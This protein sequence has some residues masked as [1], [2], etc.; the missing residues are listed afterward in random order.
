[1]RDILDM[2]GGD[3]GILPRHVQFHPTMKLDMW[4]AHGMSKVQCQAAHP[5]TSGVG[6]APRETYPLSLADAGNRRGLMQMAFPSV[7]HNDEFDYFC[8]EPFVT[9]INQHKMLRHILQYRDEHGHFPAAE[10]PTLKAVTPLTL[11]LIITLTL[12]LALTLTITLTLTP[13]LT[14]TLTLILTL[15]L[16][17][18]LTLIRRLC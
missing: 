16:T 5:A 18:I 17:L 3:T 9:R 4:K 11:T 6:R 7:V 12:A 13:T 10:H 2:R 14:L 1:M 8:D 15:R